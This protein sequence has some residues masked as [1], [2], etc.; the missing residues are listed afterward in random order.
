MADI[1][2]S[3]AREDLARAQPL[4]EVLSAQGWSVFWDRRIPYGQD[5]NAYIQAQLDNALCIIV[6]WSKAA[7][8]SQFVRDEASEGL[9]GRL[10]PA[11]IEAVTPPLGFRQLQCADLINW[12]AHTSDEEFKRLPDSIAAILPTAPIATPRD[13]VTER[14]LDISLRKKLDVR[15]DVYLSYAHLDN[16]VLVEGRRG[17]VHDL[18]RALE[19]RLGQ[20]IGRA[21]R[22]WW[23]Q[24]LQGDE[25]IGSEEH[26]VLHDVAVFVSIVSP[27]YVASNRTQEQIK[28]FVK[29]ANTQGGITIADKRRMFKI[30]KTPVTRE[31]QPVELQPLL[32][33]EFFAVDPVSGRVREF[34]LFGPEAQ[35]SFWLKLDDVTHDIAGVLETLLP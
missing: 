26:A 8:A 28:E 33:Y 7:L 14:T 11:R 30:L 29:A 20:I 34:D 3:Y 32:G 9:N 27:R 17:W 35:R 5:F 18:H 25:G 16:V 23:N 2:L 4:A 19:I 13:R 10:V 31:N 12:D 15:Y 24:N 21:A 6:L 22:V 1:F